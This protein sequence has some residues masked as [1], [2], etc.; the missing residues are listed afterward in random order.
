MVFKV[1]AVLR[2]GNPSTVPIMLLQLLKEKG[3]C[4]LGQPMI[5]MF[6]VSLTYLNSIN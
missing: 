4:T 2:L 3:P 1:L 5:V 6:F